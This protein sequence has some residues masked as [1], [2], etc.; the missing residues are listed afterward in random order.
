MIQARPTILALSIGVVLSTMCT[1]SYADEEE[2]PNPPQPNVVLEEDV[3]IVNRA[4]KAVGESQITQEQIAREM[5]SN[6][7]D[8]VRYES[9]VSVVEAGRMG[10]SGF[11]I[12]GVDENRVAITIDGLHQAETLSSQGFKELFEGYGNFN[13]TR[14]GVEVEHL[15]RATITKGADSVSVGSG[16]LGGS[17][18]YETKEAEDYLYDKDYY[19][20]HKVGYATANNELMHS[21]TLAGRF[22]DLEALIIRTQ[23]KGHEFENY[24]YDS[25]EEFLQGRE[26]E[27]ADPY[28]INKESWL[29]KLSYNINDNHRLTVV[30]DTSEQT[31]RGNDFSYNLNASDYYNR[32]ETRLRHTDDKSSREML[33]FVYENNKPNALWDSLKISYSKQHID[34]VARTDDYCDG[35]ESCNDIANP[36]GWQIKSGVIVD[37]DGKLPTVSKVGY[38]TV[39]S[40]DG[41]PVDSKAFSLNRRLNQS[42]FDCSIFDCQG[43]ILGY[44]SGYDDNWNPVITA[45]NFQFDTDN[46][47]TDHDG[48]RYAKVLGAGYSDYLLTPVGHGFLERLYKE[49][50]LKTDTKQLDLSATKRFDLANSSHNL[51]YGGIYSET[52]KSMVNQEGS[53]AYLPQ[54]WAQ[55]F[56]GLR[57]DGKSLYSNCAEAKDTANVDKWHSRNTN[58]YACPSNSPLTS[59]LIP[60]TTKTGALYF[61]D[62]IQVNDKLRLD[63]G[64]RY[65]KIKYQPN[66]VAGESPIIADDM[67][68][69]LFVPLPTATH[70]VKPNWWDDKYQ[71]LS[72]PKFIAD[73][74]AW[75]QAEAA[76]QQSVADNPAQNIAYFAKPKQYS[77]HSYALG[78]SIRPTDFATV[79]L[80]Y[81][82]SFRAPT[83]D[84][85]Y[86]TFKHP[87]FTILPNTNLKPEIAHN[88]ELALTLHGKLGHIT[89]SVF[90]SDYDNFLNLEYLGQKGFK[91]NYESNVPTLQHQ[92]YQNVNVDRAKITGIE[93]NAKLNMGEIFPSAQGVYM[94]YKFTDQKGRMNGDIPINAIQPRT[95]VLGVGY[96]HSSDKFGANLYLTH[97][98]AKRAEDTY[99]M[100]YRE[101]GAENSQVKW[102]SPAYNLWDLTAYYRPTEYVTLQA[103]V[104]NLFNHKYLTWDAARS[105]RSFGTSNM[106]N[107]TTGQGINRFYAPERNFKIGAEFKF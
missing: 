77:A 9:G 35:N 95:S 97:V 79:Q 100:F 16:A 14:N 101:E 60:V 8:L 27:K 5:S 58:T 90:R 98:D 46:I 67:V 4:D 53:F 102:R 85:M 38:D 99:N 7:K 51:N 91:N 61:A 40:I 84:E 48:K 89:T 63:L 29:A 81:A 32:A 2:L 23:R 45:K 107:Q 3:I 26:R 94:S 33:G 42:W 19:A 36:A 22:A 105:I 47:V 55:G 62:Q 75:N 17:V 11:A 103:G 1:T 68:K 104:Y 37:K 15:K 64:Y 31:S 13:N 88:K 80:K 73:L 106:I 12:R 66:Y 93:V 72:D 86:F 24:G 52:E 6:I 28:T 59:F 54:W 21:T 25:Y 50:H 69:G 82:R 76:Y 34:N 18:M 65:D 78:A 10:T 87:D 49:R 96:D 44:S 70:G 71:G 56:I 41:K 57:K 74:E 43:A 83:S 30:G 20:S 39:V 92:L